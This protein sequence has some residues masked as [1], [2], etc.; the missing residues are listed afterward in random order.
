VSQVMMVHKTNR[1]RVRYPPCEE[2]YLSSFGLLLARGGRSPS[3]AVGVMKT[4]GRRR[5]LRL[6]GAHAGG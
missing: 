4:G 1:Q 3:L 5:R 2:S 6:G